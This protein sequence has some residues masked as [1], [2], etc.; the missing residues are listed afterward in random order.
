MVKD[1]ENGGYS[2]TYNS[3]IVLSIRS[4]FC[5]FIRPIELWI[6]HKSRSHTQ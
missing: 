3:A 2:S 4:V 5:T 1:S 6:P